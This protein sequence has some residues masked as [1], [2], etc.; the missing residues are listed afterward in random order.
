MVL[1]I[2]SLLKKHWSKKTSG[3]KLKIIMEWHQIVG[4]LHERVRVE[5]VYDDTLVL[6]VYDTCWMQELHLLSNMIINKVNR[7]VDSNHIK[8]IRLKYVEKH[9]FKKAKAR[10]Y[11]KNTDQVLSKTETA[12]LQKMKNHDLQ[13]VLKD[14]LVRCHNENKKE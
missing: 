11:T 9:Q 10:T 1:N 6:G 8:K 3:W 7:H 4:N 12:V 13:S 5:K 14:F 2:E